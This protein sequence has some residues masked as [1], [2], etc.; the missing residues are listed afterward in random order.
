MTPST[1]AEILADTARQLVNGTDVTDLLA[2]LVR[3]GATAM[4]ADAVGLMVRASKGEVELLASTSHRVSEL[5][6]FQ[7]LEDSGPCIDTI[8]TGHPVGVAGAEEMCT[9]WPTV[10]R[11]IVSRGFS[12]VHAFP[13]VW[14]GR[15]VGGL[16]AFTGDDETWDDQR[17]SVGQTFADIATLA[18]VHLPDLSEH[19]LDWRI[20]RA[21]EG[22]V[23]IEQAKGALAHVSGISPEEAYDELT[24]RAEERGTTLT[25]AADEVIREAARQARGGNGSGST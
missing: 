15:V 10:G 20:H 2:R 22:R 18:V 21:L 16:N 25:A 19:E 6:I 3:S 14:R 12:S 17:L 23:V 5:E 13:L 11:S 24:R 1:H 4:R 8:A 9:R 7:V